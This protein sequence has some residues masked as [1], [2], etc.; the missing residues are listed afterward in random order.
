M[1][2]GTNLFARIC[3][4]DPGQLLHRLERKTTVPAGFAGNTA[5]GVHR[6]LADTRHLVV[7]RGRARRWLW[8]RG[9]DP[10]LARTTTGPAGSDQ[11]G[12]R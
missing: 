7:E 6:V 3:R 12:H 4:G 9:R 5:E 1:G 10:G 2:L 11:S 8:R